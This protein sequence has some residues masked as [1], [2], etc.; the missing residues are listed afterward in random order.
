MSTSQSTDLN[1][2]DNILSDTKMTTE[3][4]GQ[5]CWLQVPCTSV[6]R[7]A[8]LYSSV[9]GWKCTDTEKGNPSA[10]PGTESVHHFTCCLLNGTFAKMA[11]DGGVATVAD[12]GNLDRMP[13]LATYYVG[14]IGDTLRKVEQAGGKVHVYV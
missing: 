14:D 4:T 10:A 9:L 1:R 8:A 13:V 7:A 6:P 12:A 3:L 2:I 5:I 11:G